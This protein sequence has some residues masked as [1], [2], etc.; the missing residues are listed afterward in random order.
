METFKLSE[1]ADAEGRTRQ[2]NV[3]EVKEIKPFGNDSRREKNPFKPVC[4][5]KYSWWR[6]LRGWPTNISESRAK[7]KKIIKKKTPW[8]GDIFTATSHPDIQ[9]LNLYQWNLSNPSHYQL[10]THGAHILLWS[11][12]PLKSLKCFDQV[13]SFSSIFVKKRGKKEKGVIDSEQSVSITFI[14]ARPA[15]PIPHLLLKGFIW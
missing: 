3:S 15:A 2:C 12:F 11:N 10:P 8:N 14:P 4:S 9:L 7:L 1:S 6:H 13:P 5:Q